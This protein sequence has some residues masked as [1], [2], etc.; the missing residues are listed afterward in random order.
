MAELEKQK[1]LTRGLITADFETKLTE[2]KEL[3]KI[4]KR[5]DAPDMIG[6]A[7]HE[8]S[9]TQSSKKAQHFQIYFSENSE[10]FLSWRIF[11]NKN[12]TEIF[13]KFVNFLRFLYLYKNHK[14]FYK[15]VEN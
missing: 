11:F 1:K 5:E 6:I 7:Y 9:T 2:S 13:Y 12:L 15:I 8:S 10:N 14:K 4:M 3:K